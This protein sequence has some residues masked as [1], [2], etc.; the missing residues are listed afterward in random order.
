[1]PVRTGQRLVK[2][3]EQIGTA[4]LTRLARQAERNRAAGSALRAEI[5]A[6]MDSD[7]NPALLTAK[8]VRN[9]L[10][11]VPSP[12]IRTIQQHMQAIRADWALVTRIGYCPAGARSPWLDKS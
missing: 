8:V 11:W 1:M 2:T 12:S 3:P 6:V 5:R 10:P 7:A 4:I 9:R